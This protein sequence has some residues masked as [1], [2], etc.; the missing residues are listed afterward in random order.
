[1][2]KLLFIAFFLIVNSSFGQAKQFIYE[3]QSIP[4]STQKNVG[5]SEIMVLNILKDRSEY[6]SL[7]QYITDSTL[8]D[9]RK[10]GFVLMPP[11]KKMISDRIIKS[12]N[13]N[14]I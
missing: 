4:D 3:Y 6:F 9:G 5:Q 12:K 13:S 11:N 7:E 8:L 1:M 14:Q 2:K 10:K